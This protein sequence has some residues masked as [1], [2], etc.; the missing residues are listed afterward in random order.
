[1]A[2]SGQTSRSI[3]SAAGKALNNPGA[4]AQQKSLAGSV[5][6][7]SGNGKQT[8]PSVAEKAAKALNDGRSNATTKSLAGSA[9]TQKP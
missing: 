6:S 1:M 8:S 3:A 9:L 5:L 2:K 4:S 7:Q